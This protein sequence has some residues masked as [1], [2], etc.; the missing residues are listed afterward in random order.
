MSSLIMR[1]GMPG[2]EKHVSESGK[3]EQSGWLGWVPGL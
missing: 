2:L 3:L 1:I